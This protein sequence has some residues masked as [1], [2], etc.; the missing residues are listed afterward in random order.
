[1]KVRIQAQSIRFRLNKE[2]IKSLGNE[3]ILSQHTLFSAQPGQDL[4]YTIKWSEG[5]KTQIEFKDGMITLGIPESIAKKF[6][7]SDDE[8]GFSED[9]ILDHDN[10]LYVLVEKD[11]QCLVPRPHENE[12]NNFPNP[13]AFEV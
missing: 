10:R 9:I 5:E 3:R 11:F 13:L 12:E 2:D 1:M 7:F 6:I 4:G 8:I